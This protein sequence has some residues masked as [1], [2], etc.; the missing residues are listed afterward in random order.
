MKIEDRYSIVVYKDGLFN[1]HY[2]IRYHTK[3]LWFIPISWC[4]WWDNNIEFKNKEQAEEFIAKQ[5][6]QTLEAKRSKLKEIL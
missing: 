5:I 3:F 6:R 2:R 1:L 4:L